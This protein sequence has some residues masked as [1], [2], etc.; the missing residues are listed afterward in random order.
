MEYSSDQIAKRTRFAFIGI[1]LASVPFWSMI[2]LLSVLLYKTMHITPLQITLLIIIKPM[3]A[4]FAP[5]WSHHIHERP[6]RAL[7]NLAWGNSLRYL[8][9]LFVP[10]I[11]SAW[12][13]I[14][15][16]GLYMMFYR[17][18]FTVWIET[19]KTKMPPP[20]RERLM[21]FS[22]ALDYG[23]TALLTFVVGPLLDRDPESWRLLFPLTAFLGLISTLLLYRIPPSA[24]QIPS[25]PPSRTD[26][27]APW[28]KSWELIKKDI[29][30]SNFQIGF[31]LGGGGLMIMQP[32][33]PM[34]FVDILQLSYT[35]MLMAIAVFKSL[36]YIATTPFWVRLFRKIN[37][38]RFCG[39]VTVLIALFPFLLLGSQWHIVFL[40]C[41]YALY[42]TMQA[43]SEFC[44]HMSGLTFSKEKDSTIYSST[45]VLATGIKGCL[46]PPLGTLLYTLTNSVMV[47][48]AGSFLGVLATVHFMRYA[49]AFKTEKKSA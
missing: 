40:Y 27:L 24:S 1:R 16:F 42:G 25:A 7:S 3:S 12:I 23:L 9:F 26:L 19:I 21:G 15:S 43:G 14:L 28:K 13:V 6:D 37:I 33:I 30:F 35:K 29:N 31:M 5:Y 18:G 32:A 2:S 10:W 17:A 38:Y 44:W 41:A 45:N 22:S 46:I 49:S 48:I 47:M 8:P 11:D 20:S 34:I 39:F 36:G 4:L